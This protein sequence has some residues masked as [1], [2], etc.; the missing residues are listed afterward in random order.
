VIELKLP[1]GGYSGNILFTVNETSS[2][3][4]KGGISYSLEFHICPGPISAHAL[5]AL[6]G[7]DP[8]G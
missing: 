8:L 3:E 7:Y 2:S 4:A 6:E 5:P 1:F